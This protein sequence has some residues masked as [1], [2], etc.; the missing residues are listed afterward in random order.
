MVYKYQ[1][2]DS[3]TTKT[4]TCL[5]YLFSDYKETM[6]KI[7][8]ALTEAKELKKYLSECINTNFS[9][10]NEVYYSKN[11]DNV[12]DVHYFFELVGS[13]I[14]A[15]E[16]E[17]HAV[18]HYFSF[19]IEYFMETKDIR[20]LITTNKCLPSYGENFCSLF[21]F[22]DKEKKKSKKPWIKNGEAFF[23]TE[24]EVKEYSCGYEFPADAHSKKR[25]TLLRAGSAGA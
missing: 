5:T 22:Y 16:I 20:N 24:E 25:T 8:A 10:F 6:K 18:W 11:Y 19:P 9:H 23:L 17:R 21:S 2:K 15:E 13:L 1:K 12:R 7:P 3:K 14:R 4:M